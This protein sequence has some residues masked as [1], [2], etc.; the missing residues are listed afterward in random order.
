[1]SSARIKQLE[2]EVARLREGLGALEARLTEPIERP[3]TQA[4]QTSRPRSRREAL[5]LAALAAVGAGGAFALRSRP[6]EAANGSNMV[7]GQANNADATTSLLYTDGS[8]AVIQFE[9]FAGT[10][11]SL[12]ASQQGFHGATVS[13]GPSGN[14]GVDGYAAGALGYGVLGQSDAG[15]GVVGATAAGVDLAA[16]GTG[17]L[18]QRPVATP[19]TGQPPPYMPASGRFELVRD[20]NGLLWASQ[21]DSS[22]RRHSALVTFPDPRRIYGQFANEVYGAP[23]GPI[24]ATHKIDSTVS[25]V[26]AGAAAVYAA[27]QS[28]NAPAGRLTLYPDGT[29]NPNI[30]NW[31][32][33]V[34]NVLNLSYMLIP[35]SSAGKFLMQTNLTGNIFID[36]WGY[37]I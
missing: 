5:R 17:R 31:V 12:P 4:A 22:W 29:T 3:A 10:S 14:D 16:I 27:V 18:Q 11:V 24:D 35:L 28:L 34:P 2:E 26:P 20:V 1:M 13:V 30:T 37:V 33:T 25:G 9:V 36:A 8:A 21:P 19:G 23:V 6:V 32:A 15:Y 7:V